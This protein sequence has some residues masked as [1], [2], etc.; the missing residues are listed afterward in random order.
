MLT[1]QQKDAFLD[2]ASFFVSEDEDHVTSLL[3]SKDSHDESCEV[4]D[5]ADKFMLSVSTGKIEMPRILCS[6]GKELS[7]FASFE[8]N[9][10]KSRLWDH[11]KV[12]KA[13]T[14][15]E[16]TDSTVRGILLDVSKLEKGIAIATNKLALM[17]NLRY[18]KIFDSSCPR[19]C[20][21]VDVVECKIHVP[22]GL[23]M[24]LKKIRYLHWLKFPSKQLPSNFDAGSLI[25]LR[26]PY[27][28][29]KCIWEAVK[30]TPNLKWVDLSHST[31]LIDLSALC[32]AESLQRLNLEGCTK[33]VHL[34][35]D[36]AKM[37]SL[38]FLNL[39]RCTSLLS[40]PEMENLTCLTT[41]ILSDCSN[42]YD[43]RVKSK[44]L[45][46]LHLDGTEI[47][48]LP[49]TIK[50]LQRL[51]VLNLKDCKMLESL[52]DCLGKLKALEELILSGCSRLMSFPVIK[53]NMENL[54]ILLLDGTKF[55][56]VPEI[57]LV[58]FNSDQ[59]NLLR[60]PR[61]T[62]GLSLLR[63]LCLSGNDMIKSLQSNINDLYHLK[64]IDL[65]YCKSLVSISTLP[66]NLQCLD[67]HACVL[68]KTV[69][70]PLAR[71]MP[72]EQVSS[73]FIFTN[74]EKLEHVAKNEITCYGHN[75]GRFL[76][77]TLNR[78]NKGL[79]FE[80]LVTTCFPGSEVPA[81]FSHKASGA[82]LEPE[83]PRHW[84]ESGFVGIALCAIVLFQE[85][86]IK[87]NNLQVNCICDFNNV[88]TS[89]SYFS[90]PVGGLSETGSEQR[91]INSTHVFIGYTNWLNVK[92]CQEEDGKK[93][94]VPTK[95]SIKF[96]VTNDIGEVT[97]CEVLKCGFSLVYETGQA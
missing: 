26:L 76:S 71:L 16:K 46:H 47:K 69:A 2:I 11:D 39:R 42:F 49:E 41:L 17:P 91:T 72:T 6:L 90:C 63:R 43:F 89:S 22:D 44:N 4:G 3:A 32:Q 84:S 13:L 75:K 25:D 10:G 88:K 14:T 27:S 83:L 23:D 56:D 96:Q 59:V 86:K 79:S 51:I 87:N 24:P 45:E 67:A 28:K 54:Q 31:E 64:L 85:Q 19:Q 97:N 77:E 35:K 33:L 82:V 9:L 70:S 80:A 20:E 40:L 53:E 36:T 5:L 12:I 61:T 57:L 62:N 15:N 38:A 1:D 73:S 52:P 18:L 37:K 34:P 93:G 65:K 78:H 74:C 66:P 50:K 55:R 81:W 94:C 8:D 7:S 92:K 68:L 21:A 60:S 48:K 29:I 30:A 95:A 58:C